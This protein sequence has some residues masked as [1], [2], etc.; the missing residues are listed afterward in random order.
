MPVFYYRR[1]RPL[2]IRAFVGPSVGRLTVF[3]SERVVLLVAVLKG[4]VSVA[5]SLAPM[6]GVEGGGVA[7]CLVPPVS[8]FPFPIL[9]LFLFQRLF[10]SVFPF[11][12]LLL[13][14]FV[15]QLLRLLLIGQFCQSIEGKKNKKQK[16][17]QHLRTGR[18][19]FAP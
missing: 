12:F 14:L 4:D 8:V 9:F 10:L 13:F 7:L 19:K 5:G 17:V 2:L 15:F 1:I 3:L 11:P 16:N 6:F 18:G